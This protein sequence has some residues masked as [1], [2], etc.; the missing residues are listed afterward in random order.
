MRNSSE[1]KSDKWIIEK[2]MRLL[3]KYPLCDSCLGRCFARLG[4]GLENRERGKAIK[5]SLMLYLDEKIKNHEITDLSSIKGIMENLGSIGEKWFKLYF[6][7]DF[8]THACYICKN[9]IEEIKRDFASK[10]LELLSQSKAKNYVLGVELDE[11]I[12]RKENELIKEFNLL[13]YESIKYEI[14]RE[15]GKILTEKGYPPNLENPEIE[16]VYRLSDKQ[17]FIIQKNTRMLYVYNRLSRNIPISS[18]FSREKDKKGLDTLL[19]KKIILAFSEPSEVRIFVDYPLVIENENR[20]KIEVYGYNILRVMQIGRRE[21]YAISV[22]KPVMKKYRVSFYSHNELQGAM[23]VYD[24]LYDIY[25][26]ARSFEE[27]KE[28]VN[29]L[30]SEHDIIV[31]AIDLID[32]DG[33]IKNIIETYVKSF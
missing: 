23:R 20:E 25:I 6:S 24:N 14:K 5:I 3:S 11:E 7:L 9:E 2:A 8:Q 22:S 33:K 28:K 17:I 32:I 18:W 29:K 12:K 31:L 10:A 19:Q 15:V 4:Y 21:L 26:D 30:Q 27:L 16:I 1:E 13:Y